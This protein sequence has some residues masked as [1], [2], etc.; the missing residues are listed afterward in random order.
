MFWAKIY[1]LKHFENTVSTLNLTDILHTHINTLSE[2]QQ[3]MLSLARIHLTQRKCW[4]LDEPMTSLD[5]QNQKIFHS[6]LERHTKNNGSAIIATHQNLSLPLINTKEL[7]LNVY[8]TSS[9]NKLV[10]ANEEIM[11]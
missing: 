10:Y 9:K 8:K 4:I 7:N 2:G 6:M 11:S 5:E 1:G 3:R